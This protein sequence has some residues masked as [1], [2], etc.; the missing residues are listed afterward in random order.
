MMLADI[1]ILYH[2]RS[3]VCTFAVPNGEAIQEVHISFYSVS[4]FREFVVVDSLYT[5]NCVIN[6]RNII[7]C[8]D[9]VTNI[10]QDSAKL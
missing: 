6:G 7:P 3:T 2:G 1:S 9:L 8:T 5:P 10:T 4:P